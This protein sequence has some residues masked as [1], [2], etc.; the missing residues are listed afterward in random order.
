M[1]NSETDEVNPSHYKGSIE[2]IDAI[3]EAIRELNGMDA[4]CT[5]NAIKY[6]WRW[7]KK[8]GVT[9][10]KKAVWYIDRMIRVN[11]Q[12]L[13]VLSR[14]H[15]AKKQSSLQERTGGTTAS[16][17]T[18]AEGIQSDGTGTGTDEHSCA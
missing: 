4:M 11:E 1:A 3:A 14:E 12:T 17:T 10:L 2:C 16:S 6:L 8:G 5:G 9:D 18:S 15:E 7:K 13:E